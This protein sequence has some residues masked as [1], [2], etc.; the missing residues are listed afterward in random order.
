MRREIFRIGLRSVGG[1]SNRRARLRDLGASG[2]GRLGFVAAT[3]SKMFSMAWS[4]FETWV[5][6]IAHF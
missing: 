3:L 4:I 1:L 6:S 5:P 2:L